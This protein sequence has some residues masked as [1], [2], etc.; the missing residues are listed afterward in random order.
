VDGPGDQLLAG[1]GLPGEENGRISLGDTID[2]FE[3][4]QQGR[5]LAD[6]LFEV[7]NRFDFFLKV[8]VFGGEAGF[9]LFHQDMVGDVHEHGSR[10]FATGFRLRP[11]LHQTGLPLSLRRNSNTAP[12]VS[13]PRPTDAN[14][15]WTRR[16]A[17]GVLGTNDIPAT[18][19]NHGLRPPGHETFATAALG[20]F[21]PIEQSG[22]TSGLSHNRQPEHFAPY[23]RRNSL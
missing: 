13:V 5:A 11:P 9:F 12:R 6:D 19:T 2:L 23:G 18:P 21:L 22:I 8:D 16:W 1:S 17:S 20:L 14:A 10:V 7:V 15:S 4:L 3:R